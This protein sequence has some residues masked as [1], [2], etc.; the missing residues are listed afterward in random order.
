MWSTVSGG[1]SHDAADFQPG[2]AACYN[3]NRTILISSPGVWRTK[4]G[5][6]W[7]SQSNKWEFLWLH[8][9]WSATFWGRLEQIFV[10]HHDSI[11]D[12]A[13]CL[14]NLPVFLYWCGA[15]RFRGWAFLFFFWMS[16]VL[17]NKLTRM[18]FLP[19]CAGAWGTNISQEMR[20]LPVTCFWFDV[21]ERWH[22]V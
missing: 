22:A 8:L 15:K 13:A 17:L 9:C 18:T 10:Q 4:P 11:H 21:L 1:L 5:Q 16:G 12:N 2:Q 6:P 14:W 3:A 7:S 20:R 19:A